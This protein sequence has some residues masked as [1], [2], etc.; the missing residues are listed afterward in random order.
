MLCEVS[1]DLKPVT[2]SSQNFQI[3]VNHMEEPQLISNDSAI[4]GRMINIHEITALE[5]F[6]ELERINVHK[7]P[8]PDDLPNWVLR[9]YAFA[10]SEP[11]C[12][13]FNFSLQNGVMPSIWK[14]ANVVPI[15][16][17]HP[18]TSIKD[19]LHPISLTDTEQS[20]RASHWQTFSTKYH[21]KFASR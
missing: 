17:S 8:G 4:T 13:I 11:L 10:I 7:S 21:A 12:H 16:K 18:P 19:D 2:L 6:N 14:A 20:A 1:Q 5:V 9:E 15:P 3:P